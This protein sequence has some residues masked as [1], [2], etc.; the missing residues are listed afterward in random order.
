MYFK[1]V[2]VINDKVVF[3]E[4]IKNRFTR[5]MNSHLTYWHIKLKSKKL[6]RNNKI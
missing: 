5:Y 1:I 4:M 3:I 2:R 6:K